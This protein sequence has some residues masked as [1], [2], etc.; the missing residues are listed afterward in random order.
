[1]PEITLP[2]TAL[3]EAFGE[4]EDVF[5]RGRFHLIQPALK[6]HR[7]GVDAMML[8]ASVPDGFI[9][10]VADLGAGAGAA[11][12]AVAARCEQ[13]Q[14]TLIERSELMT[15]FAR[16]SMALEVNS[17]LAP[18]LSLLNADVSL[19]GKKRE[20]A[21]LISNYFDFAIMNPPFNS[22]ADRS[23]PHALKAE[24]H[25]MPPD[26]FEAWIKTAAA[27]VKPTGSVAIIARPASIFAILTALSSRFGAIRIIPVHPRPQAAA[28]RL[29]VI[30][31]K[32][33]KAPLS[34]EPVLNLHENT[35]N[36]FTERAIAINNG[37]TSLF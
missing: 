27:I 4:T 3:P 13:A 20:E 11:G 22:A 28:I 6:G 29:I 21:G 17:Q 12:F 14:V 30:G 35:G 9:G 18:R 15:E 7:S 19:T 37:L 31:V 34:F 25:V 33:S 8:A 10:R 1:M 2:E 24:A 26:M 16:K 36:S 32:G 5:H 23:T